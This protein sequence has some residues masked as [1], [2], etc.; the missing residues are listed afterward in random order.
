[1]K[2]LLFAILTFNISIAFAQQDGV[3][4]VV[5]MIGKAQKASGLSVH[6]EDPE[7][8]TSFDRMRLQDPATGRIPS[9]IHTLETQYFKKSLRRDQSNFRTLE[10]LIVWQNRGP[11]N[12]GGRTRALAIDVSDEDVI[13]AGGVSGGIWRTENGGE[14]WTKTTGSNELQS[15]TAIAQDTRVGQTDTWYY[16]T[17]EWSGNSAAA[18]GADYN[19]DGIFKSTDGGMSW[20]QLP[21]TAS[22]TPHLNDQDFDFN[23]E[24]VVSPIDGT[25]AVANYGGVY[26]STDE[27]LSWSRTYTTAGSGWTDV[28]VND[29]G[30]FYAFIRGLG[31]IRSTDSGQSWADI[32]SPSFPTF[33]SFHRGELAVAPSNNNVVYLLAEANGTGSGHALWKYNALSGS[34]VNRSANIPQEGGETG[35]FDSQGGYDLLIK[36]KPDDEN[37]VFIGGT[38]LYRSTDGFASK[39]QTTWI[40]GYTSE[41]NSFAVYPRHHPD[42]HCLVF[43][44]SDPAKSI[45]GND[46]GLQVTN[47]VLAAEANSFSVEWTPINNGYLTTQAYAVSAGPGDLVVAGFQD[48]GSWM[49]L[50][51]DQDEDW[52]NTFSGDGAYSAIS[53]DGR[54]R[55]FSSQN[56]NVYRFDYPNGSTQNATGAELFGPT[57]LSSPL[58]VSPLYVDS[59]DDNLVYLGGTTSLNVNNKAKTGSSTSG[60]KTIGLSGTSG[61]ISEMGV[62]GN[63][64]L[65]VGTSGGK[66]YKITGA[67]GSSPAVTNISSTLFASKYI[68]GIAVNPNNANE[69]IVTVSNYGVKSI[70]HSTNGGSSWTDVGGNL[71]ENT[72]GTGNGPSVRSVQILG[73]GA[74]YLVGTSVG[75]FTTKSLNGTSTVWEQENLN[76]LGSLVVEHMAVRQSDG[77]VVAGTHGNG[78][79]SARFPLIQKDL[80]VSKILSPNSG[81]LS[82]AELISIQITNLGSESVS[83]FD[84]KYTVNGAEQPAYNSESSFSF[85]AA[86]QSCIFTN[87]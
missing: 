51:D 3:S 14:S 23:H 53:S 72:N 68:S 78:V 13:L 70:F 38:N 16:A 83:A 50:T 87:P 21:T 61:R 7:S 49:T 24:I 80:A 1:M 43:Y 46:G 8:R 35:D 22:L 25:V 47:D 65:Y 2:K 74:L 75:L 11:F 29:Q 26:I 76:G 5:K 28:V 81:V 44:P 48:N 69:L 34:W 41:N 84:V 63:G 9:D 45:S 19:G 62:I 30:D 17:G 10:N 27:G 79:F 71:E 32:S 82:A 86:I 18:F 40:G 33:A 15:V 52:A 56:A 12:V 57:N 54:Q 37:V 58:F 4:R 73:D 64:A 39:T 20:T 60:W 36:V 31:V 77:L 67:K 85:W 6:K 66:L 42:Q 59:K 55:Y